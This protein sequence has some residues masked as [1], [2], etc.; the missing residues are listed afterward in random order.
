M[1]LAKITSKGQITIPVDI[2]RKLGVK[3]GDKVLFVEEAGKVYILNAS[4]EAIKE[5]QAAF[6]GEAER[7]GLKNEDDVVAMI[8]Q[9]RRERTVK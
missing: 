7:A 6:A 4:M 9:L 1:E 5:A 3:E 2:R 8:K